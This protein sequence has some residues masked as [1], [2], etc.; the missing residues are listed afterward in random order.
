MD[1]N[2]HPDTHSDTHRRY[3][4][5]LWASG[6][7]QSSTMGYLASGSASYNAIP[8]VPIGDSVAS[9]SDLEYNLHT[10]QDSLP[11]EPLHMESFSILDGAGRVLELSES[12]DVDTLDP[13]VAQQVTLHGMEWFEGA[14]S[15][16]STGSTGQILYSEDDGTAS[17]VEMAMDMEPWDNG[18]QGEPLEPRLD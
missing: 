14:S 12:V 9:S 10:P 7:D 4:K 17:F 13:F 16:Q 11:H 18:T 6:S 2:H 5:T 15:S 3:R 1:Q 8:L